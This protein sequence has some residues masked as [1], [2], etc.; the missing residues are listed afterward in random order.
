MNRTGSDRVQMR[1]AALVPYAGRRDT[2]MRRVA[3]V[4]G[5]VVAVAAARQP[6]RAP[7]AAPP[8]M[9]GTFE[10]VG[11]LKGQSVLGGGRFVFLYGP[12]DGNGPMTGDAGTY[13]ISRD[14]ATHTVVYST[15]PARVG[16]TFL[17]TPESWSGD[18]ATYGVM[19]PQRQVTGR[20]RSVRRH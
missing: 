7:M 19:N 4:T 12:A 2:M 5:V 17:W 9:E 3:L 18:T 6:T 14:T 10:Y 11:T 16:T 15:D 8:S 1:D 13:R 20:G